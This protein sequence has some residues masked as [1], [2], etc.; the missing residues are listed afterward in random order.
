MLDLRGGHAAEPVVLYRDDSVVVVDKPPGTMVHRN[1]WEPRIE[2][3]VEILGRR[4]GKA[5]LPVHR[6]DRATS[7]AVVFALDSRAAAALA[8]Q[9]RLRS[10]AKTYLAIVRGHLEHAVEVDHP[11]RQPERVLPARSTVT[12]LARAVFPEPAGIYQEAWYSLVRVDLHTGRSHQAR[13]HLR[14]LGHPVIGDR[15]YGDRAQNRFFAGRFGTTE[16]FLR[17]YS[18]SFAHPVSDRGVEVCT[19]VPGRW[20]EVAAAVGLPVPAELL[21]SAGVRLLGATA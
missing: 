1:T 19:G 13:R 2:S 12:P 10:V 14:H 7:G 16:M 20:R 18:L 21:R 3:C 6:I 17:A 8:G 9:F 4:L 15:R 5:V 11:I